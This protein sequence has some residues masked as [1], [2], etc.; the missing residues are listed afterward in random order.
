MG[1]RKNLTVAILANEFMAPEIGRTG[2][3][4]WAARAAARTFRDNPQAG[5]NPVFLTGEI[6]GKDGDR[7]TSLDGTRLIFKRGKWWQAFPDLMREKVDLILTVDYRPSYRRIFWLLPRTPIV[8]WVR[9]PRTPED[10]RRI[11]TLRVPG[12]ED[13]R[14]QGV[15]RF[16]TRSLARVEKKSRLLGRKVLLASKFPHIKDKLVATYGLAGAHVLPNPDVLDYDSIDSTKH[17][18]PRVLF[19]GRLDPIKRPWLFVEL[20]RGFPH[21]E[22]LAL[23]RN[24]FTG[25]GS[26]QPENLPPNLKLLG[27]IEGKEKV[28][29]LSSAWVLVNSSIYEESPVSML[30]AIACETT[31]L[32]CINSGELAERFG[33]FTGRFDGTGMEGL[34]AFEAGLRHLLENTSE[35]TRLGR[36]GRAWVRQTHNDRQFL[37]A[38]REIAADAGVGG[39]APGRTVSPGD[40][41][42]AA[43][44]PFREAPPIASGSDKAIQAG[45]R[46]A[47]PS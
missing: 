38:F 8:V 7:E 11:E 39:R 35:R 34:P 20:A 3:F 1:H 17:P 23:G 13:I 26:W 47:S 21:V 29:L 46:P 30:E 24:H 10:V 6:A 25:P 22:F 37:D 41:V 45:R 9:D 28:E 16:D 44:E 14:P 5:V 42:P 18:T 15:R 12:Q 36:E 32:S 2:G 43:A 4:G 33:V 19:L 27:H 31:I 40:E